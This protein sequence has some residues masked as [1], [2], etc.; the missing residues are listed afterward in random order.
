[1]TV[2][3][4]DDNSNGRAQPGYSGPPVPPTRLGSVVHGGDGEAY[5]RVRTLLFLAL[6]LLLAFGWVAGMLIPP[7]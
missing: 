7:A 1:M 4:S 6:A 5:R 2:Q 3:P